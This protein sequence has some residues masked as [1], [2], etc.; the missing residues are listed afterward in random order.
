MK[1]APPRMP[2]TI[3]GIGLGLILVASPRFF[4][5]DI[6]ALDIRFL[7]VFEKN[8]LDNIVVGPILVFVGIA[9]DRAAESRRSARAYF[10]VA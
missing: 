6:I 7:Q 2:A 9:I 3:T 4:N 8:Q 1:F 5:V 10:P